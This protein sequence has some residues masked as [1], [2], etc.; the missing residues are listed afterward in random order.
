MEIMK[1]SHFDKYRHPIHFKIPQM[2]MS[3]FSAAQ[4]MN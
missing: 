3:H 2:S 4:K 1:W